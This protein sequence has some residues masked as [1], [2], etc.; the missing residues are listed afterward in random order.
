MLQEMFPHLV[1]QED[2]LKH[3]LTYLLGYEVKL[4]CINILPNTSICQLWSNYLPCMISTFTHEDGHM[5][6]EALNGQKRICNNIF[7]YALYKA[8]LS[9]RK[10]KIMNCEVLMK[11][12]LE[13]FLC[14]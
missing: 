10:Y 12:K 8:F 5:N 1:Y 11:A 9:R 6:F 7:F 14:A 4:F 2:P 13:S 3:M